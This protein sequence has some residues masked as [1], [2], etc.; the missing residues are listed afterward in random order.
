VKPN[1]FLPKQAFD[2]GLQCWQG[3]LGQAWM[4]GAVFAA[5]SIPVYDS[6]YCSSD[7]HKIAPF[8]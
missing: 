1:V 6:S 7:A 4:L 5:Y 2:P 8:C 3:I